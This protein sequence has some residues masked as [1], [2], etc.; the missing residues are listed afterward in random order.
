MEVLGVHR[1][2]PLPC[3]YS[4]SGERRRTPK[5]ERLLERLK[6]GHGLCAAVLCRFQTARANNSYV[7]L[8]RT[9]PTSQIAIMTMA[10][11]HRMWSATEVMARVTRAMTQRAIS[12]SA[13]KTSECLIPINRKSN[14]VYAY[15]LMCG[16]SNADGNSSV[17]ETPPRPGKPSQAE[18][19]S[20]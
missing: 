8:F 10:A 18:F 7:P 1:C 13:I 19:S 17:W 20:R 9:K 14:L 16:G 6:M 3:D 2:Q 15:L 4:E 12:S 5:R 11:I